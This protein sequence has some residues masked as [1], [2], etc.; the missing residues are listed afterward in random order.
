M[1]QESKA[2][3]W[4]T[5]LLA[6]SPLALVLLGGIVKETHDG[7]WDA[8]D[9]PV[10]ALSLGAFFKFGG[11]VPLWAAYLVVGLWLE[12]AK[13]ESSESPASRKSRSGK[14]VQALLSCIVGFL[15]LSPWFRC[16]PTSKMVPDISGH[17]FV[18]VIGI[19][20]FLLRPLHGT[21]GALTTCAAATLVG[22][23]AMV[24]VVYFHGILEVVLGFL[25]SVVAGGAALWL[26]GCASAR[27]SAATWRTL[28][29]LAMVTNWIEA[30]IIPSMNHMSGTCGTA[31]PRVALLLLVTDSSLGV[32]GGLCAPL[33]SGVGLKAYINSWL[34]RIG[35]KTS[36]D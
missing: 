16:P 4:R 23:S 2:Q 15:F 20:P 19:L 5:T 7:P 36:V 9:L 21:L 27:E 1:T 30:Y 33:V 3:H 10:L 25:V 24:T 26:L 11:P 31:N 34:S 14:L 8:A 6:L 13:T 22:T 32:A 35:V 28:V 12:R 18:Y 29:I 17:T